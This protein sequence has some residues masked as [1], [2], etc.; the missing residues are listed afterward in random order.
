VSK[1]ELNLDVDTPEKVSGVLRAAA[2][3]YQQSAEERMQAQPED[4]TPV[5]WAAIAGLLD[6]AADAIE[7]IVK[8]RPDPKQS[9]T[10]RKE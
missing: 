7:R 2:D 6:S 9:P 5:I 4:R 10:R 1:A 3:A 8:L